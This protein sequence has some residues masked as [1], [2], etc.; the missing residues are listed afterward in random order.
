MRTRPPLSP[1]APV[2]AA[3]ARAALV[4]ALATLGSLTVTATAPL[5]AAAQ[6]SDD[7]RAQAHFH[8]GTSY[9]DDGRFAESAAEFDEA[10]R[11]SQRATLLANAS[12][13][14]ERAGNLTLAIERLEAYFAAHSGP[15][16]GGYMTSQDRLAGLRARLAVEQ[17]RTS[18]EPATAGQREEGADPT[19]D[20]AER[21]AQEGAEGD[22]AGD[23]SGGASRGLLYAGVGVAG[24][25]VAMG[26]TS[27]VLHLRARA[28][29]RDLRAVCGPS[30]DQ[31]PP[32][33]A[34][35][36]AR[37]PRLS[38]AAGAMVAGAGVSAALGVTLALL[39]R[40]RHADD[41]NADAQESEPD[42]TA[43]LDVTRQGV[44]L[45][46]TGSF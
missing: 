46:V 43:T 16:A 32:D 22:T 2:A 41:P 6:P 39:G 33:R 8:A 42:T 12:L 7:E 44:Y 26:I 20:A 29:H 40:G 10:Y 25:G 3:T 18:T 15:P 5:R 21:A 34:D 31:C 11:L 9:F 38:H 1:S 24:A 45:R 37:G 36:I 35:D 13:A 4:C 14:Y 23:T 19:A 30:G 28:V 27:L 17:Q